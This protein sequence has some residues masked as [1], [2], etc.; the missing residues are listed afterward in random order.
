MHYYQKCIPTLYAIFCWAQVAMYPNLVN[1]V[2]K[3]R[4]VAKKKT[5]LSWDSHPTVGDLVDFGSKI[6]AI[7][8]VYKSDFVRLAAQ[9]A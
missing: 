8:V 4:T 2:R 1:Q 6:K 3:I 5:Y 7:L 9:F